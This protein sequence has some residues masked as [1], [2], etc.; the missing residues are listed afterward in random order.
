MHSVGTCGEHRHW[1][2]STTTQQTCGFGEQRA[3]PCAQKQTC[4][5]IQVDLT[6]AF[7]AS[8][9]S[10]CR[11]RS[12]HCCCG[13]AGGDLLHLECRIGIRT[14]SGFSFRLCSH[15]GNSVS[16]RVSVTANVTSFATTCQTERNKR[17]AELIKYSSILM[18]VP[19]ITRR[20]CVSGTGR[21]RVD[22]LSA[23]SVLWHW[24]WY[25]HWHWHWHWNLHLQRE[26]HVY[27]SSIRVPIL[28]LHFA[29]R[30]SLAHLMPHA[31]RPRVLTCGQPGHCE[32]MTS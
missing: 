30:N 31:H 4:P 27:Y 23:L 21:I 20:V 6:F 15:A 2:Y 7:C 16:S 32:T 17:I 12:C 14:R 3:K 24:H 22:R 18:L 9:S 1:H 5:C 11:Y 13:G 26:V 10:H 28:I 19:L 29:L 25:W 8:T